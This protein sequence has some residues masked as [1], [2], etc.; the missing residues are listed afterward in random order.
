[1]KSF[2]TRLGLRCWQRQRSVS[3]SRGVLPVVG[4]LATGAVLLA[5]C[6]TAGSSAARTH[7]AARGGFGTAGHASACS[8]TVHGVVP[9][10]GLLAAQWLPAGFHLTS[11][12]ISLPTAGLTYSAP[13]SDPARI[14]LHF[15][16][17]LEP[18]TAAAGGRSA[19]TAIEVQAHAGLLEDGPPDPQFIGVYWKPTVRHEALFDREGM[20]GPLL[21][22][23]AA[24]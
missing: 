11:G 23:V 2:I 13:G 12:D 6:A 3:A 18:L 15:S 20:K 19:A 17:A 14:E 24:A 1:M 21:W 16:N 8:T 22:A 4:A 7:V 5:S 10:P 9:G